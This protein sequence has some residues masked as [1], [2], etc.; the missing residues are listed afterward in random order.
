MVK[1]P[2]PTD[3]T[4]NRKEAALYLQSLGFRISAQTLKR[5]AMFDNAGGGPPFYRFNWKC[6]FYR[7]SDLDRWATTQVRRVA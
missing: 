1:I 7:Q 6:V 5:L 4:Y 3:P 2:P